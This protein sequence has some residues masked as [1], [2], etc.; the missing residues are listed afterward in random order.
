MGQLKVFVSS[1]CYDL[2]QIR[3]DLY[4]FFSN[5]GFLPILSEHKDF[6]INPSN[7]TIDN[8]LDNIKND[9]DIFVLVIG[10][11]YGYQLETGK[12]IT[13]TEYLYA[14][15][16]GIPTYV[17]INKPIIPI[18][19]IWKKNKDGNF[20][21]AVDS[22]KIFEFVSEIRETDSKWCFEFEKAQDIIEILKF[23]LSHLFKISLEI[24][25]KLNT[26]LP[27]FHQK[28]SPEAINILL[29]KETLF[30][31]QFFAQVLED[32]LSKFEELKYDI[33]YQIIFESKE[34]IDDVF[35]LEKWLN[36]NIESLGHFTNSGTNLMNN[37]FQKYYGE[38]GT[39][40]DI[41]GLYYV[42][43]ALSRLYFEMAKWYINIKS[44]SVNN[45][46]SLLKDSFANYTLLSAEK[47]WEF[48]HVIKAKI[49]DAKEK[50]SKGEKG[51]IIESTLKFDVDNVS[52]ET[53][54]KEMDKLTN[55]I[56]AIND[57]QIN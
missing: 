25:T 30:E 20:S 31:L 53:F 47:I 5:Y 12:S 41:K 14:K 37:A 35:E 9:T 4:D 54:H 50:I 56:K 52:T 18:L 13:N 11:R 36:Q 15:S 51:I 6:P 16:L 55:R 19:S 57:K 1:T 38:S 40:S 34:R 21:D 8:C 2:K 7:G 42:S 33:D 45:D 24:Q 49:L 17:F 23:Q 48:P 26:N 44:T 32:E 28:L 46:F 27:P 29:K 22:T 3:S 39:P 10:N 43:N